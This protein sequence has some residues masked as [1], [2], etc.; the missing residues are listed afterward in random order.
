ME[1]FKSPRF[2][3]GIVILAAVYCMGAWSEVVQVAAESAAP[4]GQ[5]TVTTTQTIQ[6]VPAAPG[7]TVVKEVTK[8][9]NYRHEALLDSAGNVIDSVVVK[10]APPEPRQEIMRIE[11]RPAENAVWVPGYWLWN[12]DKSDYDWVSGTWRRAIPGMTWN[13]GHWVKL[14]DGYEWSPGFWTNGSGTTTTT[15]MVVVREA[16]PALKEETR[17]ASPGP[18]VVWIP[19][20]WAYEDKTFVWTPGRWER[21]AAESMIWTSS[22]WVHTSTGYEYVPGHWDYPAESRTFTISNEKK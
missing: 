8:T 19:G 3:L 5:T 12:T 15:Q 22:R 1:I 4:S 18:G 14:A 6:A 2:I 11:T 7:T 17:S 20:N 16:P 9:T 10:T 21:P 13:S